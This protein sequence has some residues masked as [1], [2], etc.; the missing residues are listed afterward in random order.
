MYCF[1]WHGNQTLKKGLAKKKKSSLR[2]IYLWGRKPLHA[3]KTYL[4][5]EMGNRK[6]RSL[7]EILRKLEVCLKLLRKYDVVQHQHCRNPSLQGL[8][9][10]QHYQFWRTIF[11]FLVVLKSDLSLEYLSRPE[12]EL[13]FHLG[14]VSLWKKG[15]VLLKWAGC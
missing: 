15:E 11:P 4:Q 13:T 6:R 8:Q 1:G 5:I 12:A 7:S 9:R 2:K 14:D 3:Q 10:E